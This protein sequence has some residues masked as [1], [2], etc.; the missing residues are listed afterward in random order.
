MDGIGTV[1]AVAARSEFNLRRLNGADGGHHGGSH[2]QAFPSRPDSMPGAVKE[3]LTLHMSGG[4]TAPARARKALGSLER[5]LA[6]L[7]SDVELLVSEL[8]SNS[9]VHAGADH[10]ELRATTQ[11]EGV[12]V[13]VSDPGVGFDPDDDRRTPSLSGEGGFGLHIVD[14]VANRWGVTRDDSARVW[15]EI[16]RKQGKTTARNAG[17]FAEKSG[18]SKPRF[19]AMAPG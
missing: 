17:R 10:V 2:F 5:S 14:S 18:A 1:R 4:P 3:T 16:D 8:V 13:E 9:V 19:H 6:D 7:R 12:H 15:F 11:P